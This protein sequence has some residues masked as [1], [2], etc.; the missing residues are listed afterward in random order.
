MGH[1]TYKFLLRRELMSMFAS[2]YRFIATPYL[3]RQ[4]LWPS[5]WAELKHA[6]ALL[7]MVRAELRLP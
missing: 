3:V 6:W 1:L 2:E 7:P 5:A 4:P